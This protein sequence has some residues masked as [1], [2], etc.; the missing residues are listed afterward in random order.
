MPVT[1]PNRTRQSPKPKELQFQKMVADISSELLRTP[2]EQLDRTT[3]Y[4]LMRVG[5]FF[6]ADRSYVFQ[7]SDCL[8]TFANTHEW[9]AEGVLP[10]LSPNIELPIGRFPWLIPKVLRRE[11]VQIRDPGALPEDAAQERDTF[12]A[13]GTRSLLILPLASDTRS[14]GFFGLDSVRAPCSWSRRRIE[15]LVVVGQ[16][17]VSALIKKNLDTA[18]LQQA[19]LQGITSEIATSFVNLKVE[20]ADR[21]IDEALTQIGSFFDA[22]RA[23]VFRFG[24]DR[25]TLE[26]TNEWCSEGVEPRISSQ[27]QIAIEDYPGWII[28]PIT[29]GEVVHR[30]DLSQSATAATRDP[31]P[32][33]GGIR[34]LLI[35]PLLW[36]EGLFGFFGLETMRRHLSWTEKQIGV[37]QLF[38]KIIAGTFAQKQAETDQ[39]LAAVAF[40]SQEGML[41]TDAGGIVQRANLAFT[42]ITSW[43]TEDVVGKS[44]DLLKSDRREDLFGA[45]IKLW[46]R[47]T[48]TWSGEV[49][50]RSKDG[51]VVPV[52]LSVS[53]VKD[54]HA[55]VAHYVFMLTDVSQRK[56]NEE[57]INKLAF[58]D[59]LTQLPNRR[60]LLIRLHNAVKPSTRTLP[61]R[62]VLLIDLDN[63]NGINNTAGYHIG[64]LLLQ[65][66]A[67]RVLGSVP[68]DSMVGRSGGDE[69]LVV[70]EGLNDD[71]LI[72]SEQAMAV[73][74]QIQNELNQPYRIYD[75]P[76]QI[77]AS[78]GV[79]V[80]NE[81]RDRVSEILKQAELAIYHAKAGGRNVVCL[82]EPRMQI[83]ATA[84]A[85]LEAE[86]KTAV[87]EQQFVLHYQSQVDVRGAITGAETLIRWEHPALG[88]VSPDAFIP[89]A[90][91]TG[92]I[93]PL[94]RWVLRTACEQLALWSTQP[95]M[96]AITLSI[97]VSACEFGHAE[98]VDGVL[99]VLEE[100]GAD[101][102]RLKLELTE[103]LLVYDIEDLGV[104]ME[105]LKAAGVGFSL[106]DF[107]TGYS[108]LSRLKR[109][110]LDQ[111]KI[112]RNFIR[113]LL[114][115]SKD[116]AVTRMVIALGESM[117][118][119]VIA[120]GVDSEEQRNALEQMGCF[121]YQGY[122]FSR[123]V[124]LLEFE[125]MIGRTPESRTGPDSA[126]A[127]GRFVN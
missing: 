114:V 40:E 1:S 106:D 38:S 50:V 55:E 61:H 80:F 16:V 111:L 77:S 41:V 35:I 14:Y 20:D 126:V 87:R 22:D 112:D 23:Y 9:C 70:L 121:S 11:T 123:P 57:E 42:K 95:Q 2:L 97:N 119:N 36:D 74:G 105:T 67:V 89:M 7:F 25:L 85:A 118:L 110:P 29:A 13:R 100:T 63:F 34:S 56:A 90:E 81:Y 4:A 21:E 39:R 27:R 8:D 98:F 48:G 54:E 92:L 120:E 104:K 6:D 79:A 65:Q 101:P 64:D 84:R 86:L 19:R 60:L 10:Y 26:N 28:D 12:I 58:Y 53:V 24:A 37:L 94:G 59:S 72:A 75:S 103:S 73:A 51:N 82:F 49:W 15:M 71:R 68:T 83:V 117:G 113:N 115:D 102:S 116:V 52:W 99:S 33:D 31:L 66:V 78:I 122:L 3:N 109:L 96:A 32:F 18:L 76:Y 125:G 45:N 5:T 47:T 127:A 88:L 43:G 91:E 30:P 107:G 62:A 108:S 69:F 124:P 93:V 17:I 44:I 46:L